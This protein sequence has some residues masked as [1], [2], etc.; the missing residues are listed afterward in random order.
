[1]A[2]KSTE[3]EQ[4]FIIIEHFTYEFLKNQDEKPLTQSTVW[5]TDKSL[6]DSYDKLKEFKWEEEEL[7]KSQNLSQSGNLYENLFPKK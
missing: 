5:I 7:L 2:Y 6:F 1:M 4:E 3:D